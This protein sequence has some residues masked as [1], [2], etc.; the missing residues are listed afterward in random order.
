MVSG[1][2]VE[3]VFGE[4]ESVPPKV[5]ARPQSTKIFPHKKIIRKSFLEFMFSPLFE[6]I[7]LGRYLMTGLGPPNKLF[8]THWVGI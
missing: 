6:A 7:D 1:E 8:P 4:D 3:M 5:T 2:L